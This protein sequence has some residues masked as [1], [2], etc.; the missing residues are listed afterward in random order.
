VP[1]TDIE[2]AVAAIESGAALWTRDGDFERI[3]QVVPE[4]KRYRAPA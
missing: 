4:L 2:I 3:A 1:L